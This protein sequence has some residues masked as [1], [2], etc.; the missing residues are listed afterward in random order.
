[1]PA[2]TEISVVLPQPDGPMSSSTSPRRTSRS[3][4]RRAVTRAPFSYTLVTPR[5]R[6][7]SCGSSGGARTA[8]GTL[9]SGRRSPARA[10]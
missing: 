9:S 4:P 7:A 6:S 2:M 1:M 10:A 5:Q 3:T 8:A